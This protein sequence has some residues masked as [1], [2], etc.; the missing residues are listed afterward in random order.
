MRPSEVLEK[1][2]KLIRKT[3]LRYPT[4]KN[5]RVFGSVLH[6]TDTD[7]SDLDLLVDS[8][9]GTTLV[10]VAKL[11]GDLEDALGIPVHISISRKDS[12]KFWQDIQTEAQPV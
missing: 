5:P 12:A 1:N 8:I 7:K 9:R 6:G 3:V 4:L 10:D 11:Q 2:R